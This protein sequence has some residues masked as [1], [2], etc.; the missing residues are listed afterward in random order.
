RNCTTTMDSSRRPSR[1]RSCQNEER[2]AER[3]TECSD[4]MSSQ[5]V[6]TDTPHPVLDPTDSLRRVSTPSP[7]PRAGA[8]GRRTHHAGD[9]GLRGPTRISQG[10]QNTPR[11]RYCTE[12]RGPAWATLGTACSHVRWH[13]PPITSR[14]P[15][16]ISKEIDPPP[17]RG[18]SASRRGSPKD[19]IA[20]I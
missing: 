18:R 19:T 17:P 15:C 7:N 20:T 12:I 11:G 16:P 8:S 5:A 2:L 10:S 14:S 9:R 1:G 6:T 3:G 13:E 4:I